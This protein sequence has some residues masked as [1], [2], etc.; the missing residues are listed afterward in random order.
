MRNIRKNIQK[1]FTLI[2]LMIVVA[3]IGILAA[4]AIPAYQDYTV[5]AKLTEGTSLATPALTAMG[6]YCSEGSMTSTSND[7]NA[8]LGIS[9]STTIKGK[10]VTSVL[11][12]IKRAMTSTVDGIGTVTVTFNSTIAAVNG[13]C[14]TYFG[15]CSFAG[16]GLT[17][18]VVPGTASNAVG[19]T[20]GANC[21][22]P[23]LAFP[24]KFM[25]KI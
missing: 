12:G 18:A 14:F 16:S 15:T 5:K 9:S 13:T 4:V 19:G 2:E 24:A 22:T 20:A 21:G 3:I 23:A 7:F 10:Y 8:S 6:V 25:P 1:G 11:T 17:W